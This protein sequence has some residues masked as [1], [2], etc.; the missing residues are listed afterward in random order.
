MQAA[1][2]GRRAGRA[3]GALGRDL[4]ADHAG[5]QRRGP[6]HEEA[7]ESVQP[8]RWSHTGHTAGIRHAQSTAR[9]L[10][11]AGLQDRTPQHKHAA[12]DVCVE[13]R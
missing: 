3:R 9:R 2:R 10:A 7:Q 12:H 1:R 8:E 4:Q 11:Q 6:I 13:G 5:R